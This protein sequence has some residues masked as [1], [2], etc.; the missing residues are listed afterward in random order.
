[1][2]EARRGWADL[3]TDIGTSIAERLVL[4]D[5]LRFRKVCKSWN[6]AYAASRCSAKIESSPNYEPWFILYGEESQCI[7]LKGSQKKYKINFPEL[8]GATCIA[9]R[10]GWLLVHQETVI[11][12]F[13]PFSRSKIVLPQFPD[14]E[15]RDYIG[16]FSSPPTSKDCVVCV[17]RRNDKLEVELQLLYRGANAWTM[18]KYS[19]CSLQRLF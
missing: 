1:M 18:H 8:D 10:D 4:I 2:A 5:L 6:S 14:S 9:S 7:L 3:P 15:Q 11:F 19:Y 16:A 13:C 12:F 17:V